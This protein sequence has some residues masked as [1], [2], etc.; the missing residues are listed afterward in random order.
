[1]LALA[2]TAESSD[3]ESPTI[4]FKGMESAERAFQEQQSKTVLAYMTLE[5][6]FPDERIRSLAEAAGDGRV[7]E[8]DRLVKSGVDVNGRGTGNATPLF[9]AMKNREGFTKLL[10]LGADPNVLFDDGGTM[11]HWG[12]RLKDP[13]LLEVALQFGGDPNLVAGSM[14][15]TPLFEAIGS[16]E[17]SITLLLDAGA[18]A[19][20]RNTFGST[21]AMSAAG[22][23]RF[24][25]VYLLL[26]RGAS[27]E[28]SNN[29]G[30]RLV[31]RIASKQGTLVPNSDMDKWLK[32]VIAWLRER[33][34]PIDLDSINQTK[35]NE[36]RDLI[37]EEIVLGASSEAIEQFFEK[38]QITYSFD[39]FANRYQA[40]IRDVATGPGVDQAIVIHVHVDEDRRFLGAEVRDSFTAP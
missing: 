29:D 24:D 28:V 9:W 25:V 40:I 33:E 19:D 23:G 12:A 5:T 22:I 2:C 26:S 17:T 21:V 34:G 30:V 11:M 4:E 36:V 13:G 20:A 3:P 37:A 18:N 38:H 1:M 10:K 39:R 27:Y 14:G 16:G 6:M 8:V 31:D 32:R 15:N 7:A 35:A